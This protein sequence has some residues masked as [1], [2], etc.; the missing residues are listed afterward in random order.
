VRLDCFKVLIKGNTIISWYKFMTVTMLD[1]QSSD[2]R[3]IGLR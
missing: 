1:L 2:M 3:H